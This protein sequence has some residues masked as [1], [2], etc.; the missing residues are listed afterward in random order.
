M[1][2]LKH[3][4]NIQLEDGSSVIVEKLLGEGGQGA[5]YMVKD[6]NGNK[7]ALKWYTNK[8]IIESVQFRQN[9][10]DNIREGSYKRLFMAAQGNKK[11]AQQLWLYHEVAP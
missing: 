11:T 5:V 1:E 6:G 2:E 3:G 7:Y 8:R 9:L 10:L 4:E